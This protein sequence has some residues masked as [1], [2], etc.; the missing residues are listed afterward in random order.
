MVS[1]YGLGRY[2]S[3]LLASL[4]VVGLVIAM[5]ASTIG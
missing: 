1:S 4:S 2:G 3:R 5:A